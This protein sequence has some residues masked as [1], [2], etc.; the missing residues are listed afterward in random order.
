[1]GGSGGDKTVRQE[2]SIPREFRP[3][4]VNLFNRAEQ[5]SN[6]VSSDPFP[7]NFIAPRDPLQLEALNSKEDFARS[8]YSPG[9]Y[10][11]QGATQ[12]GNA[13]L[14]GDFLSPE[15]NPY[16]QSTINA[17][18]RPL[19]ENFTEQ[20]LPGLK[21][22]AFT[23]GADTGTRQLFTQ[24]MFADD[25]SRRIGDISSNIAYENYGRERALQQNA[26]LLLE[27]GLRLGQAPF[28][29]LSRVGDTRR[30][31][32]QED[33]DE[34]VR[35]FEEANTAPFR[36]LLPL[37]SIIQGSNVGSSSK[38]TQEAS[39]GGPAGGIVGALGGATIAQQLGAG[40]LGTG[41]AAIAG[42]AAGGI[43]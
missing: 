34:N 9:N 4:Y 42:G 3:T 19:L 35:Q 10:F 41:F 15:S 37:A 40:V 22:S 28:E 26:P 18:T 36:P 30:G 2:T 14:R 11:G 29:L 21:A 1:M 5:A 12:L 20:V 16:L 8:L 39:S 13:T 31:F 27:Q 32:A 7:G 43:Y 33:V 38:Q 6:R 24:N 23:G 25:L 17:A